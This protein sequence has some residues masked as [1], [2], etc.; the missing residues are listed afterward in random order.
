MKEFEITAASTTLE[1]KML[2]NTPLLRH[3]EEVEVNSLIEKK[4]VKKLNETSENEIVDEMVSFIFKGMK[5]SIA[6]ASHAILP[7]RGKRNRLGKG[8]L[9]SR[10]ELIYVDD[11]HPAGCC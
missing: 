6:A 5:T 3:M 11:S 10:G 8:L 4:S 7:T 1:T 2:K 9:M